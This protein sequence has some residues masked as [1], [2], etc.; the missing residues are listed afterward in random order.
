[1]VQTHD[2][3]FARDRIVN[4]Y[5]AVG[6]DCRGDDFGICA[7]YARLNSIGLA[8][9][10]YDSAVSL[11]FPEADII[12][13]FF[14]IEGSANFSTPNQ[15]LPIGAWSPA[16]SAESRLRLDFEPGYRQLVLRI[17]KAALDSLLR[18]LL[19]NTGDGKLVFLGDDPD[20]VRMSFV[21]QEIFRF[22]EEI[23]RLG[24][25]YSPIAMTELERSLVLRFLLAHRH[26]YTDRLQRQP[27][28]AN[29]SVVDKVEAFIEANWDQPL[30]LEKLAQIADVSIR[31][32]FREFARA[33][34]GTPAQ[35][36]KRIRLRRAA[37]FLRHP[38]ERT[39][40]IGVAI[41]CGFQNLGHFASSYARIFGEVPSDTL[42]RARQRL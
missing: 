41:K 27:S 23:E 9:C 18:S 40:V 1:V 34:R 31:T 21:R 30:D 26:N 12:R 2:S 42:R 14:S 32:M 17:D 37:E 24:A 4:V 6:F 3:E 20:P 35:F 36:A 33:G 10:S 28:A 19:G 15:S 39:T 7:N 13:Q 16:L 38:D 22:A 11:S 8:F 25:D 29:R 5:G